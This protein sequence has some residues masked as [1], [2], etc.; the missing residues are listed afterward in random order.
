LICCPFASLGEAGPKVRAGI[1]RRL[2][3]LP[4]PVPA[5]TIGDHLAENL[6]LFALI[7]ATSGKIAR[8]I[9]TLV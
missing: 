5:R 8:E 6:C 9:Y 3:M 7:A 2:G 4:M 1:A